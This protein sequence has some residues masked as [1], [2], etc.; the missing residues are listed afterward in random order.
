MQV[1]KISTYEKKFCN[2]FDARKNQKK[3]I[4][5]PSIDCLSISQMY[6]LKSKNI[7]TKSKKEDKMLNYVLKNMHT[8]FID[9]E[10]DMMG[11]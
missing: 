7:I 2:S 6:Q 4:L 10:D 5:Y 8:I 9:D 3:N 11:C 1:E